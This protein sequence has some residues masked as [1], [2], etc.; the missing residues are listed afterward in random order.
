MILKNF[1]EIYGKGRDVLFC[2]VEFSKVPFVTFVICIFKKFSSNAQIRKNRSRFQRSNPV[3]SAPT[4]FSPGLNSNRAFSPDNFLQLK[5]LK[6]QQH[7]TYHFFPPQKY[8]FE[9]T[10]NIRKHSLESITQYRLSA[11]NL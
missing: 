10:N 4:V 9:F 6:V 7:S 2:L 5:R 3:T 8:V 1:V 11:R